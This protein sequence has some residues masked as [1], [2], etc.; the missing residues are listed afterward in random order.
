MTNLKGKKLVFAASMNGGAAALAPVI[1]NL[2]TNHVGVSTLSSDA[3]SKTFDSAGVKHEVLPNSIS[4]ASLRTAVLNADPDIIVTGTQIQSKASP[5]TLEQRLWKI[6]HDLGIQS[7]ALLDACSN[8]VERFSEL[9]TSTDAEVGPILRQV[10]LLPT[11]IAVLDEVQKQSMVAQGFD[12]S[13]LI[14]TGSPDLETT[15]ETVMKLS[16]ATRQEL[17]SK[18]VFASFNK[19]PNAKFVVLLSDSFDKATWGFDEKGVMEDVLK[20]LA[21]ASVSIGKINL[22]VRP[23]PFRSQDAKAAFDSIDT[24][25][26]LNGSSRLAK[27]LHNPVSARG[28]DPANDYDLDSL[29][30]FADVVIGTCN[31]PLV[32]AA[33]ARTAKRTKNLD[34]LLLFDQEHPPLK[35]VDKSGSLSFPAIPALAKETPLVIQYMPGLKPEKEGDESQAFLA[36]LGAAAR[37]VTKDQGL[38]TRLIIGA[39]DGSLVQKPYQAAVG[40][41]QRVISLI[42]SLV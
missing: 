23:H 40:A 31:N 30:Y 9:D 25:T 18:P 28:S 39:F 7:V 38:F 2:H 41:T 17:L 20:A 35:F 29:L 16:P 14:V 15:F 3:V 13:M 24:N 8:T 4:D 32:N 11:S 37:M 1:R 21:L 19:D 22:L 12:A 36:E 26:T 6:T 5:L 42:E 34:A 33:I 10:V 27:V